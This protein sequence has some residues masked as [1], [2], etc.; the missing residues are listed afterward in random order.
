VNCN[1]QL[2]AIQTKAQKGT[3]IKLYTTLALPVLLYGSETWTVK[4]K[5][6][7]RLTS[8]NEVYAEDCKINMGKLQNQ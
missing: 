2:P 4:S 3:Q 1:I 7:S 8:R 5:D 6:K